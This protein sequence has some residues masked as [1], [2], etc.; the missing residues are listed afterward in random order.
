MKHSMQVAGIMALAG[1]NVHAA[2]DPRPADV[3]VYV[4][5]ARFPPGFVDYGA[6]SRV[7][8][9]YARIGVRI[10]WHT[11]SAATGGASSSPVAIQVRY[12]KD[13]EQHLPFDSL[14]FSQP[15]SDGITAITLMYNR[16]QRVADRSG[17]EQV[18]LAHVL[19]HEIG[20]ILQ[21]TNRH[22]GTGVMKARWNG[23][24][25]DAME[26]RPLEF[27]PDDIDWIVSGLSALKGRQPAEP[28]AMTLHAKGRR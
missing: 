5:G 7:T 26:K 13:N 23:E 19:A 18:I 10:D 28:P 25:F 16:I 14:A 24:D 21:R 22:A 17:R 9:M 6:R 1:M 11:G 27:T 8:W 2:R 12:A 4:E 15:F 3:T 20:H